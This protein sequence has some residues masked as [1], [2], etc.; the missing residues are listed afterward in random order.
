MNTYEQ[1]QADRRDRLEAAAA[2][3]D[4]SAAATL[5]NARRMASV[6]P[7]GQP[8]LVGH[9]SE[10]R[11]RRYRARIHNQHRSGFALMDKAAYLR[12]KAAS[13]GTGGIS[14]DDPEAIQKLA[15]QVAGLRQ[16]QERM[17]AANKLVRKSDRGGLAGMGFSESEI[18]G[19]LTPDFC[20]RLGFP[21]YTIKNNNANIRRIDKRIAQLRA[22][23]ERQSVEHAGAGYTYCESV[24]ENR[25]MF[26]FDRK[27]AKPAREM[28]GRNGFRWSP[29]RGVAGA[30]VRLLN[31]NGIFAGQMVRRWLD[32]NEF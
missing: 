18:N 2:R 8:I 3:A 17:K 14:S 26:E 15:A 11:D 4:M 5:D 10:G 1:R 29:T 32:E 19:L 13:V 7:F 20:G 30:W 22:D 6:I 24:D 28:M 25:V 9:H 31:G 16:Q 23:L 21:D 27:P 12:R